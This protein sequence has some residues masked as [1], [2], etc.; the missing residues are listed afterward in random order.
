MITSTS[1]HAATETGRDG[2]NPRREFQPPPVL[3]ITRSLSSAN[4][5]WNG[6]DAKAVTSPATAARQAENNTLNETVVGLERE[7]DFHFSKLS[8]SELVVQQTYLDDP[9]RDR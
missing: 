9:D 6:L 5:A 8:G 4:Q 3:H 2:A 7:R 1:P